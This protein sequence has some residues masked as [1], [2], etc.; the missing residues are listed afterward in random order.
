MVGVCG[1]ATTHATSR[2]F[3]CSRVRPVSSAVCARF[4][5]LVTPNVVEMRGAP[6]RR[7]SRVFTGQRAA[8]I[9]ASLSPS[10]VGSQL[11]SW[12]SSSFGTSFAW[13]FM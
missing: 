6:S 8:L 9:H 5:V 13:I 11:M 12:A 1:N 4:A 10:E 2:V 7:T 3:I